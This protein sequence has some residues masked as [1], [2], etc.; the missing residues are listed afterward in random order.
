MNTSHIKI[1]EI[2]APA[3]TPEKLRFAVRYGADAV[4]IG[5]PSFSLRSRAG[6]F[7]LEQMQEGASFAHR[8][9]RKLYV[10]LNIF[11]RD[12]DLEAMRSHL[13][14]LA[15]IGIDAVIVSDPGTFVLIREL[16]PGMPIHIS[17]QA[18]LLNTEAI[19]FWEKM[20]AQR[21]VLAREL[22]L[23]E[24]RAIRKKTAIELEMFVH[25]AM[26][27]AYSGRC[28]L[29]TFLTGREA[30]RGDC[31]QPC[32]WAY[33]LHEERRLGQSFP[34]EED[35]R[36]T[37]ILNSRDLCLIRHLPALVE[38]GLDSLKIEGRMKSLYYVASVTRIYRRALDTYRRNPSTYTF[39][40][41]WWEELTK[42]SHREYTTGFALPAEQHEMQRAR[43]GDYIRNYEFVGIVT[44]RPADR[45]VVVEARNQ[46]SLGD[47]IEWMGPGLQTFVSR[48]EA[49]RDAD[50]N[51]LTSIKPQQ[52]F[53]TETDHPVAVDFLLR[54][55]VPSTPS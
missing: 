19:R 32:R 41:T 30:N 39:D 46:V 48:I 13:P 40:E 27:M 47:E 11:P 38:A 55:R 31:K 49:L 17:T 44:D 35:G 54:R 7:T 42:V 45:T 4:Y 15:D 51:A 14:N 28:L 26:C 53:R 18:N 21:T 37:F 5:G 52:S 43:R 9:G 16:L 20:G 12:A 24:I 10:A 33:T 6:N 1:P 23:E 50:G 2:L 36:Q 22:A 29:S 25:G 3:G 34:I 8:H